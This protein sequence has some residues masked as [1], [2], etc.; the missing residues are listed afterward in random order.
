MKFIKVSLSC[1]FLFSFIVNQCFAQENNEGDKNTNNKE[2]EMHLFWGGS[3]WLGLGSYTYVDVNAV[4]GLQITERFN[5]G[6]SGKYQ[7][8]ND[9]RSIA[10]NFETSVYGGSVFSQIA[11]I[12]DFRNLVKVKGHS[13]IIAHIEYEFLNTEYNYIYFNDPD[14]NYDRYWLHNILIGGGYFQQIG[15]GSKSYIILLWNVNETSN[16]PYTY[17]QLRIGFSIAI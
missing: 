8:Y 7:Y 15:K 5:L 10:G 3:L 16:N 2:K 11:I 1:L 13:G 12:K 6:L 17:P 9:K 14:L 4:F